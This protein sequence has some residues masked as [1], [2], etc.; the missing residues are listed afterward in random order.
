M[1][2][3]YS[4]IKAQFTLS[5]EF[6]TNVLGIGL[7]SLINSFDNIPHHIFTPVRL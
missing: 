7:H 4:K 5:Y 1:V 3:V 2:Q 6:Y